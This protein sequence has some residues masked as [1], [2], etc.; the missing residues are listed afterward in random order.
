MN[1]RV[2]DRIVP[3]G[4]AS[5]T[6]LD[7]ATEEV[8]MDTACGSAWVYGDPRKVIRTGFDGITPGDTGMDVR[9]KPAPYPVMIGSPTI[10]P[11]HGLKG[12]L[13]VGNK[14]QPTSPE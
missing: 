1:L 8:V 4:E 11:P 12:N 14:L 3:I 5:Q 13:Q 10:S 9:F 6:L 2:D 7:T